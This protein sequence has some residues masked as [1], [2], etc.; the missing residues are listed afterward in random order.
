MSSMLLIL[1][2]LLGIH[3]LKACLQG[4]GVVKGMSCVLWVPSA[5]QTVAQEHDKGE[6]EEQQDSVG[7][8]HRQRGWISPLH[9]RRTIEESE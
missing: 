9:H 5:R 6:E 2:L 4:A 1:C 3:S 8:V 7:T